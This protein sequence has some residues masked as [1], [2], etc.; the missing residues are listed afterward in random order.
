MVMGDFNQI[1]GP[2]SRAPSE[3]QSALH[4]T[5]RGMTI[6]TSDLAFQGHRSIDHIALS[7]DLT[8]ESAEAINNCHGEKRLSDH[9]GVVADVA[10]RSG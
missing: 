9:F 4:Q 10:L 5:L 7:A 1:V 2:G 6:T 8:T 3:L